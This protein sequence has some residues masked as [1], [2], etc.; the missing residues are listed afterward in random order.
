MDFLKDNKRLSFK[1]DDVNAW[2]L[3]YKCEVTCNSNEVTTVYLFD[4]GI[5]ITNTAKKIR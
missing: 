2:D 5:K 4:G 1:L 3:D